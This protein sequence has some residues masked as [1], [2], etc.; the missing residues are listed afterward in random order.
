MSTQL[1]RRPHTE[2]CPRKPQDPSAS[3]SPLK[4]NASSLSVARVQLTTPPELSGFLVQQRTSHCIFVWGQ[5]RSSPTCLPVPLLPHSG[6]ADKEAGTCSLQFWQRSPNRADRCLWTTVSSTTV[7]SL[8]KPSPQL[9]C[10][11][12]IHWRLPDLLSLQSPTPKS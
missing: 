8:S 11:S 9:H 12:H 7:F 3:Q 4:M 1:S 2:L 10:S 5:P 6:P